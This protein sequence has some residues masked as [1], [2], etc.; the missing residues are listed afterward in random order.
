MVVHFVPIFSE[1]VIQWK[2]CII[3]NCEVFLHSRILYR[4]TSLLSTFC[5]IIC[6]KY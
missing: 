6:D 3:Y 4:E 5:L 2:V 1:L